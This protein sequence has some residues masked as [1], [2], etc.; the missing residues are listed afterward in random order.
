MDYA[1]SGTA[2]AACFSRIETHGMWRSI[3]SGVVSMLLLSSGA[4]Q[5]SVR[6]PSR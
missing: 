5:I 2:A 1:F 3:I 4:A 6:V